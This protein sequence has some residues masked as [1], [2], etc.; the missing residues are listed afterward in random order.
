M[1]AGEAPGGNRDGMPAS[2]AR[3]LLGVLLPLLLASGLATSRKLS[4]VFDEYAHVGAG[5]AYVAAD[6]YRMNPE[7]PPLVKALA[8]LAVATLPM[9]TVRASPALRAGLQWEF[10]AELLTY[11]GLPPFAV[12]D[13]A[14]VPAILIGVL[15]GWL[16]FR[17]AARL[18]G[19]AAG[20]LALLLYMGHP[21]IAGHMTLV[22]TDVP[23][24]VFGLGAVLAAL[25]LRDRFS[26]SRAGVLA[27]YLALAHLAKFSGPVLAV[28]VAI[29]LL[30]PGPDRVRWVRATALA[31]LAAAATIAIGLLAYRGLRFFTL[32]PEGLWLAFSRQKAR[33]DYPFYLLGHYSKSGFLGYYVIAFLLKTPLALLL[34]LAGGVASM[35]RRRPS[36]TEVLFVLVPTAS[37]FAVTTLLAA[38]IGL[39][40][41][42]PGFPFLL[43]I[44]SRL[45]RPHAS[46]ATAGA[47]LL[48]TV[49]AFQTTLTSDP[50]G[51]T[52]LFVRPGHELAYL[53]NA[54]V[55]YGQGLRALRR[56]LEA[57]PGGPVA[58]VYQIPFDV[59]PLL[60]GLDVFVPDPRRF[61]TGDLPAGRV[62]VSSQ[63]LLRRPDL[64]ARLAA[65]CVAEREIG[66]SIH[67]LC[68]PPCGPPARDDAVLRIPLAP[69]PE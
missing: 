40:Y 10:G 2:R 66:P 45:A 16:L 19:R 17:L 3:L 49:A 47:F 63:L 36:R 12:I 33:G 42:L 57:H 13:R 53:D 60:R 51:Y 4:P 18:H 39:R 21:E 64:R 41:L 25:R 30:A 35:V 69:P 5:Y 32:Y 31:L 55:D 8:G 38:D 23:V 50:I 61:M 27:L 29:G 46:V 7:H 62:A 37:W 52:N 54:C 56:D 34:L 67:L 1:A 9:A 59:L 11:A 48:A 24:M 15:G 65:G 44:A 43:A 14:R 20:L 22:T 68:C 28:V 26:W 6:D 58:L